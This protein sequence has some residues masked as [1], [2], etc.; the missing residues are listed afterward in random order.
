MNQ[1]RKIP[2]HGRKDEVAHFGFTHDCT[3]LLKS[4]AYLYIIEVENML[5]RDPMVGSSTK[6]RFIHFDLLI[7]KDTR[8]TKRNNSLFE[9][10]AKLLDS[11][12]DF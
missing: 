1:G 12:R 9:V 7:W 8:E 10:R 5:S 4:G 6:E 2:T 11:C 3:K